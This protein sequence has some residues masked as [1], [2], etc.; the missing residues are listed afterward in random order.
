MSV[1][2]NILGEFFSYLRQPTYHFEFEQ[3]PK[4]FWKVLRKVTF[5]FILT[6]AVSVL[7]SIISNFVLDK[8]G[9]QGKNI[10]DIPEPLWLKILLGAFLTGIIEELCFRLYLK[11]SSIGLALFFFGSC[12]WISPHYISFNQLNSPI[13]LVGNLV[14]PTI[15]AT[16][17]YVVVEQNILHSFLSNLYNYYFKYIFY[18][19]V[20]F[21]GFIHIF[22]YGRISPLLLLLFPLIVLPQI[23]I[24]FSLGFVRI[25]YGMKWNSAFHILFNCIATQLR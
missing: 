14:L 21:F 4:P 7:C 10:N 25:K 24:S 23:I 1:Y 12:L 3:N 8:I 15:V 18:F 17:V 13:N 6:F 9:Y 20:L 11:F 22:N 19:S 2:I 5:L 16:V